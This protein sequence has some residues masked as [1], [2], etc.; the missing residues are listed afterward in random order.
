[1]HMYAALIMQLSGSTACMHDSC[2]DHG[3]ASQANL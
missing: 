3:I 1:M 2:M